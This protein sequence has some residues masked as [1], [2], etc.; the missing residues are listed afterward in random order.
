MSGVNSFMTQHENMW[1]FFVNMVN[2]TN[3]RQLKQEFAVYKVG[4]CNET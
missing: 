4:L 3:F 1:I 2:D